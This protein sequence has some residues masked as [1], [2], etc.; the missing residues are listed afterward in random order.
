M[1]LSE[2]MPFYTLV[3]DKKEKN[4]KST[5]GPTRQAIRESVGLPDKYF[6]L[7]LLNELDGLFAHYRGLPWK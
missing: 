5:L 3:S 6:S 4:V 1:T 7:V 2:N